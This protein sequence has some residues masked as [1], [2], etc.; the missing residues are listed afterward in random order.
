M[1]TKKNTKKRG[2]ERFH[3]PNS[4][5]NPLAPFSERFTFR[6]RPRIRSTQPASF[7]FSSLLVPPDSSSILGPPV[8]RST[9]VPKEEE[10]EA[11]KKKG[12]GLSGFKFVMDRTMV[13]LATSPN[14]KDL[15]EKEMEKASMIKATEM[16]KTKKGGD[17][18]DAQEL[19]RKYGYELDMDL[20]KSGPDGHAVWENTR[21]GEVELSFGG[22]SPTSLDSLKRMRKE[23]DL[24]SPD[25]IRPRNE[26]LHSKIVEKYNRAPN[27]LSGMGIDG[28]RAYQMGYEFGVDSTSIHPFMPKGTTESLTIRKGIVVREK[29]RGPRIN[30]EYDPFA[31]N[32]PVGDHVFNRSNLQRLNSHTI[33]SLPDNMESLSLRMS[34]HT[35]DTKV[36][37]INKLKQATDPIDHFTKEFRALESKRVKTGESVDPD[38][39]RSFNTRRNSVRAMHILRHNAYKDAFDKGGTYTDAVL[40]LNRGNNNRETTINP[41]TGK[42]VLERGHFDGGNWQYPVKH[43]LD[44]GGKFTRKEL[45]E[46]GALS[47]DRTFGSMDEFNEFHKGIE[48]DIHSKMEAHRMSP[49]QI[50]DKLIGLQRQRGDDASSY[51]SEVGHIEAAHIDDQFQNSLRNKSA[52]ELEELAVKESQSS[53][54]RPFN[55]R[56]D[57]AWVEAAE[58]ARSKFSRNLK[59]LFDPRSAGKTFAAG[60]LSNR[61]LNWVDKDDHLGKMGLGDSPRDVAE[62]ALTGALAATGTFGFNASKALI[63]GAGLGEAAGALGAAGFLPEIAA[64]ATAYLVQDLSHKGISKG[65]NILGV[66]KDVNEDISTIASSTL[67]GAAAGA[68]FG[69]PGVAVGAAAGAAFGVGQDIYRHLFG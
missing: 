3:T 15:T 56:E 22:K 32:H 26:E 16:F 8:R 39:L 23:L 58:P 5:S 44:I 53:L 64:G 1:I 20:S 29:L 65:L 55:E 17:I 68:F 36:K 25:L 69:V 9:D 11:K 31:H 60:Y 30:P 19:M 2:R 49:E 50:N 28:T 18:V 13:H 21:T 35:P 57:F 40:T 66:N 61:M 41:E 42:I 7:P 33:L 62:G 54:E 67:G 37:I 59:S 6:K 10:G 63:G 47:R 46:M 27:H 43:W 51:L 4:N 14:A 34:K 24:Q 12:D 38:L 52:A 45:V 48:R